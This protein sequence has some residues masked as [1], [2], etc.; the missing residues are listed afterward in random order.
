MKTLCSMVV[1]WGD[2]WGASYPNFIRSDN[3]GE[4]SGS[5]EEEL[6]N[7]FLALLSSK[8]IVFEISLYCNQKTVPQEIYFKAKNMRVKSSTRRCFLCSSRAEVHRS[9]WAC[10]TC[11]GALCFNVLKMCWR[12]LRFH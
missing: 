8:L 12:F 4:Y 11:N 9:K 6:L 5:K 3:F 1:P 2:T 10:T 7:I